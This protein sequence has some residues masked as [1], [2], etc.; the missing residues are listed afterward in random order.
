MDLLEHVSAYERNRD[1][2]GLVEELEKGLLGASQNAAKAAIHLQLGRVLEG[3]FLQSVKA[4]KHFQDAYKLNPALLEALEEARFVYWELGKTAMVQKLLDLELKGAQEPPRMA[5]LLVE[6]GDVCVD[7]GDLDKAAQAYGRAVSV[8]GGKHPEAQAGLTDIRVAET[9][10]QDYVAAL[11]RAAH[12]VPSPAQR[13]RLFVRAARVA[14][15]FAAEAVEG[16][17][18]QAYGADPSSREAVAL[19]EGL[20][21]ETQRTAAIKEQQRRVLDSIEDSAARSEAALRFGARWVVRYQNTEAGGEF[22]CEA[23]TLDPNNDAAYT[24]L[25]ELWGTKEGHWDRL[26]ELL[27]K[28]VGAQPQN[29]VE[30]VL[31]AR[32]GALSWRQLGNLMRARAYFERLS[33]IAPEHPTLRAFEMQIGETVRARASEPARSVSGRPLAGPADE[34]AAAVPAAVARSAAVAAARAS[35]APPPAESAPPVQPTRGVAARHQPDVVSTPVSE[36]PPAPVAPPAAVAVAVAPAPAV[37]AVAPASA[38]PAVAP[39]A[40]LAAAALSGDEG[41]IAELRAA[42]EK[43]EAGKRYNEFV[44]TLMQLAALVSDVPEKIELYQRAADLYVSKFANQ[45][46]AVKAYEAILAIDEDNPKAVEFLRADVREAPRLGEAARTPASR[47][48]RHDARGGEVCAPARD[49]EA[50]DRARQEARRVH[51]ALARG[52]RGRSRERRS[53]EQLGGILRA[54]EGLRRARDG[55]REASGSHVRYHAA[56]RHPGQARGDLRRSTVER[57]RRGQRLAHAADAR[58][59][60]PQGAGG[61]QEEVP[62]ARALGRPR[63]LLLRDR[64][65]GRVHPRCSRRKRRRSKTTLRRSAS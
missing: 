10:W 50:R 11:L 23:F 34:T 44:R 27:D 53:A 6:L 33:A 32:A 61:A 20:L 57:R 24:S 46:E 36:V 65:V 63:G 40:A 42:A 38:P 64:Q 51:R 41:R 22:L 43:Q 7:L 54:L 37:A 52:A 47:G 48:R 1:W 59:E 21:V 35:V 18:A 19:Y 25:H 2:Q 45:A 15:R 3:K 12:E 14:K 8:S 13:A 26:V 56:R 29:G 30:S 60:R 62:R 31:L 49:C 55:A 17:L 9:G 16:I 4:L 39:A 58:P 5:R 28:A